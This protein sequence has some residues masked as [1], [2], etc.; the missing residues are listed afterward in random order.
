MAG[1]CCL[2]AL[3]SPAGPK[4]QLVYEPSAAASPSIARPMPEAEL[5]QHILDAARRYHLDPY[6]VEAIVQ[7][8]SNYD[9]GA[10]S[11]VGAKGLMQLMDPTAD[12]LGV[13]Q[14]HH[15]LNNLMGGCEYLRALLNRYGGDVKLALAAYNAGPRNVEK[16]RGIPPFR[17]TRKYVTEVLRRYDALRNKRG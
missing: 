7:V 9:A 6:L 15:A 1:L 3:A 13:K 10:V 14:P 11:R 5:R 4:N 12:S 16:Y 17:E 8:E 2:G